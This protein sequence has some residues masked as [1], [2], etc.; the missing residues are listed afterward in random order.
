MGT[1]VGTKVFVEG[2]YRV[3]GAFCLGLCGLQILALALRGPK[4]SQYTWIGWKGGMSFKKDN[5]QDIESG[6]KD[7][8]VS[9]P[10]ESSPKP[11]A[12]GLPQLGA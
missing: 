1:A 9:P 4:V 10:N 6:S 8:V 3:T 11:L 5:A 12:A 7:T 2:G